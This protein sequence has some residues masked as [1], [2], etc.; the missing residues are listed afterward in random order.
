MPNVLAAADL[1]AEQKISSQVASFH[2]IKPLDDAY[3]KSVALTYKSIVTIEEH[4]RLGGLGGAV[5]EFLSRFSN[6]P[7]HLRLGTQDE[8]MH[9]MGNQEY[10]RQRYGLDARGIAQ[11]V[12]NHLAQ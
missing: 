7:S 5:A 3:L 12:S 9:E 1:L 10:A 8:F 2:T 11:Q 6:H 4:G